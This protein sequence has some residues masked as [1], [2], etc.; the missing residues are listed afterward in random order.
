M[1]RFEQV[2]KSFADGTT[3]VD[4]L[5][6]DIAD[7][8]T[9]ML[10][11]PSG[12]GKT[13][14]LR[15]INRLEE[16]TGGRVLVNGQDVSRINPTEL[17]RGI[18]YVIQHAGLF[19]HRRIDGNVATVPR[20]LG[21]ARERI[22]PKI[23]DMLET[24]GLD[25]AVGERFPHQL[26]GGQQQ[27]VG[28]ARALAGE[29]PVM[30]MDEPFAAV[31][32][33][34]RARL[35]QE[36]LDLK[37]RV[38][39]T[40]VFVTHDVDEAIKLGDKIAI[41]KEGGRLAQYGR[42]VDVLAKPANDFVADFVGRERTLKR[43]ALMTADS[44]EVTSGSPVA[45]DADAQAVRAAEADAGQAWVPVVDEQRRFRGWCH[46]RQLADGHSAGEVAGGT[47]IATVGPGDTLRTALDA[48]LSAESRSVVRVDEAG[49]YLGVITLDRIAEA[50][51]WS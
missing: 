3:A 50:G 48:A 43:L 41:L 14:S 40:I 29:P 9:V 22:R 25:R 7:G 1:I 34:V 31:D 2:T 49:H 32:P 28:V 8:E 20:L 16:A 5:D 27:R 23:D 51:L 17:R 39:K 35:Q 11:G 26:S 18:G 24:V 37:K 46:S 12:C 38:R 36:F 33:I 10:V 19:P 42:P 45:P 30:L 4:A 13:T 21:W 15:L 44:L 47:T 6:L